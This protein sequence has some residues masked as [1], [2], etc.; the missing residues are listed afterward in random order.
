MNHGFDISIASKFDVNTAIFLQN[1]A[2]WI[3]KNIANK[4]NFYQGRYWT[5]NSIAAYKILFPYWTV[6]QIRTVI[7]NCIK[8]GLII[9]GDQNKANYDK[10]KWYAL[11]DAGLK[12]FDL[13]MNEK[14]NI[15]EPA[16][17]NKIKNKTNNIVPICEKSQMDLSNLANRFAKNRKPIP[18][19]NTN[20][21]PNKSFYQTND[22]KSINYR[23]YSKHKYQPA[24]NAM[25]ASPILDEF[26]I[27][28]CL[29]T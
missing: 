8:F 10:T 3:Q 19:T 15:P 20:K 11:T 13:N 21:K 9:E 22:Q 27:K 2:F 4:K 7:T 25:N 6:S 23:D 16:E 12:L 29:K 24:P 18:D 26:M 5:Y 28:N 1:I 17:P 14:E